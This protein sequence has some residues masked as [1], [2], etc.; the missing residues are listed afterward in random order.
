[1]KRLERAR[2]I[3]ENV[4]KRNSRRSG[5]GG[6]ERREREREREREKERAA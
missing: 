1:M 3:K 5:V 6:R 2:W 4:I